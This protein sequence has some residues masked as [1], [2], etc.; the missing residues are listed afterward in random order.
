MGSI[1]FKFVRIVGELVALVAAFVLL[2]IEVIVVAVVV[3]VVDVDVNVSA[4]S[5]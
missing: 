2:A 4:G 5:V 3:V 1:R